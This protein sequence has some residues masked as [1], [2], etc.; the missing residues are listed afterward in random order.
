MT[1]DQ[2]QQLYSAAKEQIADRVA[3]IQPRAGNGA[4]VN[5]MGISIEVSAAEDDGVFNAVQY[6]LLVWHG[7]AGT[8]DSAAKYDVDNFGEVNASFGFNMGAQDPYFPLDPNLVQPLVLTLQFLSDNI[9]GGQDFRY[10]Y[11]FPVRA[12]LV[13]Y[14]QRVNQDQVYSEVPLRTVTVDLRRDPVTTTFYYD[15]TEFSI[16]DFIPQIVRITKIVRI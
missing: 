11:A 10:Q 16:N 1:Y 15:L 4:S 3:K 9:V 8:F 5:G 7:K 14:S 13:Q 12:T 6:Y 2:Y